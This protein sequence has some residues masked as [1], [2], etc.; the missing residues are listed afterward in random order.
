M[1]FWSH[2]GTEKTDP[3]LSEPQAAPAAMAFEPEGRYYAGSLRFP[4]GGTAV[5]EIVSPRPLRMWVNDALVLDELLFW[6]WYEREV[7][8]TILVPCVAGD[9]RLLVEVGARS[10]WPPF[11]EHDCP[12]R[13]RE[14]V[15]Q[16]LRERHPDCL[17]MAVRVA[18]AAA[19]ALSCRFLPAQYRAEG[20]TWQLVLVRPT[21]DFPAGVPSTEPWSIAETPTQ[22]IS[23]SSSVLPR[24]ARDASLPA[25]LLR[26]YHRLYVPVANPLAPLPPLRTAGAVDTRVEP[27]LEIVT[28]IP[29]TVEG[30]AGVLDIT[31]PVF[32]SLG[33]LA[34]QR[35]FRHLAWPSYAEAQALLP[36][37]ILPDHLAW[38]REGYDFAWQMLYQLVREPRPESGMPNAYIGTA[39]QNFEYHQ[40][41]WDSAFTAM[42]TAYGWRALPA[43]ATLDVLY[44]RQF[45][46]GYLHREHDVRDGIPT[47]FEPDFSPN[48]PLMS[49]AE[50]AIAG[51]TGNAL[52]L[53][54]VYPALKEM[55]IWLQANRRLPDGTYWTTGLANG[56]DNS[57]SLGDGYPDLTAQMAHDAEMLGRI[58]RV[59]GLDD[60]A[61]AWEAEVT[62]IGAALNAHLWSDSMQIYS[63]SLPEGGHNTNKVVTAF[64]PLWAGIVPPE[65]VEALARHLK[66]PRSFWRHHPLPS[67]AAD[68]PQYKPDGQYWLGSTWAPTNYAAIKGFDRA[69]R[70][71]LAVEAALRHLERLTEVLRSTGHLWENYCAERSTPGNWAGPDYCWTALGPIALLMEVVIGL[72]LD[73]LHNTIYWRLPDEEHIGVKHLS[74]GPATVTL[75]CH[76]DS[77]TCRVEVDTDRRFTL[78]TDDG[79][80]PVTHACPVGRSEF[81]LG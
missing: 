38:L 49:V 69:G 14:H 31:M 25:E 54:Q 35:E 73:A 22:E 44:S 4:Q 65:R 2:G 5:L 63:T 48:P 7:R 50:W 28:T 43:Y 11:V 68:S 51:Q 15:R 17:Q 77:A 13:N 79:T 57:P 26:G 66:D 53:A 1:V 39:A 40:F 41:V 52:R 36:E 55:H 16:A 27:S 12:S 70:H 47:G 62:A 56:L 59:L 34:P 75:R 10:G 58:A 81:V 42:C 72:R 60:E 21:P 32:E 18:D 24:G 76:R 20:V 46:G 6:R 78:V 74:F 8:A 23:L 19:P 71:D 9:A 33:R 45:D 67:L 80:G 3:R 64:W 30:A 61:Q 29:L 37:P